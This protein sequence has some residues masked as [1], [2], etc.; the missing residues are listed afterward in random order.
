MMNKPEPSVL[1]I[2]EVSEYLRIPKSSIYKLAQ[3]GKIPAQK[4]GRHWRFSRNAIDLWLANSDYMS[5]N[6]EAM[7]N[8]VEK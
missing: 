2:D 3:K 1:T 6:N 4:V 8:I 7:K 5:I